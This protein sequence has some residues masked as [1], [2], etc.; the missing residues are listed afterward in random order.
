MVE[1]KIEIKILL[2]KNF[3]NLRFFLLPLDSSFIDERKSK[4]K[5]RSSLLIDRTK[6]ITALFCAIICIKR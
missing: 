4:E 3:E 5:F 6:L 1:P 2:I